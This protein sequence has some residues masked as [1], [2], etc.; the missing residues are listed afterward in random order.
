M[1][2]KVIAVLVGT[3]LALTTT[4]VW[5]PAYFHPPSAVDVPRL[6]LTLSERARVEGRMIVPCWRLGEMAWEE[7]EDSS[8]EFPRYA[9][10]LD[11]PTLLVEQALILLLGGGLL[12]LV[13][14]RE[15]RKAAA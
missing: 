13:I 8:D 1:S 14:R 2:R 7:R 5:V 12:T 15:R 11:W 4:F 9:L 3:L 10:T 6:P